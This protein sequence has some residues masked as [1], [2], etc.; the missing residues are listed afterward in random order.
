MKINKNIQDICEIMGKFSCLA[1][2]YAY[3]ALKDIATPEEI[4]NEDF[5]NV[6]ILSNVYLALKHQD[7][8]DDESTVLDASKFMENVNGKK[9]KVTK[10]DNIKSLSDLA[11]VPRACVR[12]D[13]KENSHWVYVEFGKVVWNSIHLSKCVNLGKPTKARIIEER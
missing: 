12:F 10:N 1:F 2:S 8:L 9:Y 7:N 13:Y 4:N 6:A 3:A 11:N 5:I